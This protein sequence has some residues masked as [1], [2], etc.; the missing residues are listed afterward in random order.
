VTEVG[1]RFVR[2]EV[3]DNGSGF[4]PETARRAPEPFFTTRTTGLGLG[5]TVSQKI[6]ENHHGK[7]EIL[8]SAPGIVR[9]T[10]PL[11]PAAF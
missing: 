11:G 5:L 8:P 4:S 7:L 9:I 1:Q 2:I 10:L 6:I 3:Q